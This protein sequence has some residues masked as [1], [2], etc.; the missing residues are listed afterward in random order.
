MFH[1][2]FLLI[3]VGHDME[4]KYQYILYRLVIKR[5]CQH[6]FVTHFNGRVRISFHIYVHNIELEANWVHY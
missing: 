2:L 5:Q 6:G 1:C 4:G 3:V